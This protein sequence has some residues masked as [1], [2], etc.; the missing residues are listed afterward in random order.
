MSC[1]A[2]IVAAGRGN[3]FGGS[4]NKVLS[5]LRGKL[6]IERS[7]SAFLNIPEIVEIV[8][9]TNQ[10]DFNEVRNAAARN[11]KLIKTVLGGERRIDSVRNGVAACSAGEFVAIHDGARPLVSSETISL[12]IAAAARSGGSV[13]A[14]PAVD[15]IKR[16]SDGKFV[17]LTIPRNEIFQAQTPQVFR[18]LEFLAAVERAAGSNDDFTDDA[19]VAERAGIPVEIVK[20][21]PANIKITYPAD[22]A[23]AEE[24]LASREPGGSLNY[25]SAALRVGTGYDIHRLVEGRKFVLGGVFI[26]H[27]LGPLGHSDGDALLHSIADAILGAAGLEDL[28]SLFPDRDP[29]Y[30]NID[31][32]ELLKLCA[33]RVREGGFVII[34]VDCVVVAERP[35]IAPHRAAMRESIAQILQI[36]SGR[37]NVKGKTAEGIGEIGAGLAVE[38]HSAVLLQCAVL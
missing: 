37:V 19:A 28:G 1:S 11:S 5:P 30:K 18:R 35:K 12:A 3:R 9:V 8:V 36:P 16:S 14:A 15:T 10:E 33:A 32:R 24:I 31:S 34:N 22:L 13:V 17:N 26:E 38:A 21:D 4:R 27:P 7:I 6:V 20:G 2:V 29:K 25:N 23:R